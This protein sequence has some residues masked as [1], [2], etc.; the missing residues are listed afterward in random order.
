MPT[1]KQQIIADN[2]QIA[3]KV[4]Q[5]YLCWSPMIRAAGQGI[6]NTSSRLLESF[7]R[8]TIIKEYVLRE[9]HNGISQ[10]TKI[11]YDRW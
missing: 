1:A 2:T 11:L 10:I 5:L 9:I 8:Y 4:M 3:D 7:R 6:K